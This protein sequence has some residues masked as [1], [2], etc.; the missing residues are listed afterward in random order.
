MTKAY[1]KHN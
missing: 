1:S